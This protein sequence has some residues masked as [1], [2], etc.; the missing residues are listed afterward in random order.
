MVKISVFRNLGYYSGIRA[1]CSPAVGFRFSSFA[2]KSKLMHCCLEVKGSLKGRSSCCWGRGL[3]FPVATG[4]CRYIVSNITSWEMPSLVGRWAKLE[5]CGSTWYL[6]ACWH[7]RRTPYRW[8]NPC[9]LLRV[10]SQGASFLVGVWV[11]ATIRSHIHQTSSI[12]ERVLLCW[13]YSLKRGHTHRPYH[14]LG[15]GRRYPCWL[16]LHHLTLTSYHN[17][18]APF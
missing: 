11:K 13:A 1:W 4:I 5:D 6:G 15:R 14:L 9:L 10:L 18:S 2:G 3:S 12:E 16:L 8:M 7:E 17:K